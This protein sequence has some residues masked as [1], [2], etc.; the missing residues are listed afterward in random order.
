MEINE[1]QSYTKYKITSMDPGSISI[2]EIA[3][4]QSLILHPN[5]LIEHW[6]VNTIAHIHADNLKTIIDLKPEIILIG[7]GETF[8]LVP[9]S[10]LA[11][12]YDADIGVECMDTR[13]ACRTY[14]ALTAEHRNVV[15]A[16]II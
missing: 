8:Q 15:A 1:D 12:L 10:T 6:P 9:A 14:V 13:A 11:P 16:L 5:H 3:Y 2:N 4:T 7:T